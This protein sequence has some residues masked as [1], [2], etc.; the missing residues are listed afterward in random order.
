MTNYIVDQDAR[1]LVLCPVSSD[2]ISMMPERKS[3]RN[4]DDSICPDNNHNAMTTDMTFLCVVIV[5]ICASH[6]AGEWFGNHSIIQDYVS[7]VVNTSDK[8]DNAYSHMLIQTLQ[9]T[10][11][12]IQSVMSH[13]SYGSGY[14]GLCLLSLQYCQSRC[15]DS[16]TQR[17]FG[18]KIGSQFCSSR[19]KDNKDMEY[20][21]NRMW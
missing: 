11:Q 19:Q 15:I 14:S 1:Y 21:E 2:E 3:Y 16:Y 20:T 7:S 4:V 17:S 18:W 13:M 12:L 10:S 9:F 6:E 8:S 5:H